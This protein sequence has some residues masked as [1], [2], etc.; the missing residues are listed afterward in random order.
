MFSRDVEY[1]AAYTNRFPSWDGEIAVL[2]RWLANHRAAT[3]GEILVLG[4]K[5]SSMD[6]SDL[7]RR[8]KRALRYLSD[9]QFAKRGHEWPGGP[10]LA[11]WPTTSM[12]ARLDDNAKTTALGVA[13][14]IES[15]IEP[16]RRA[17]RPADLL[18]TAPADTG[19]LIGDAVV[20]VALRHLTAMVNL[21][22]GLGHPSDKTAAVD[23]F[24]ALQRGGHTWDPDSVHA[25]A[26]AN[27]W[28]NSGATDLRRIAEGVAAGRRFR[29]GSPMLR[30]DILAV[31]RDEAETST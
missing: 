20:V 24:R 15:D 18:G 31:W 14:W 23:T 19:P 6:D 29:T 28:R 21:S 27:G 2:L 17:R 26:L 16:W 10:A 1:P 25:W 12:I 22:S 11:L 3:G 4:P 30:A 9:S 8:N 7:L 13:P 5:A